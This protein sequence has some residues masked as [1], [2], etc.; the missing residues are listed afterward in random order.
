MPHKIRIL[1]VA[2]AVLL[3]TLSIA[4]AGPNAQ[5]LTQPQGRETAGRGAAGVTS[6][7]ITLGQSAP[8]TGTMSQLGKRMNVGANAYFDSVN[9]AGGLFG[10]RVR[11]IASDDRSDPVQARRNT[12]K[13]IDDGVFALFGY[14]GTTTTLAAKPA[15][16][17]AEVPLIGPMAGSLALRQ[18]LDRMIFNIRA[19]YADEIDQQVQEIAASGAH[20][21]AI[22]Y[23][24]DAFG[25]AGLAAARNSIRRRGFLPVVAVPVESGSTDVSKALSAV[26]ESRPGAVIIIAPDAAAPLIST[27]RAQGVR[28]LFYHVSFADAAAMLAA[29]GRQG[30][31]VL[32]TQVVPFPWE[33]SVPIVKEYQDAMLKKGDA[34]FDFASLEGYIAARVTVE[35]LRRAGSNLTRQGLV[36]A[37]ESMESIDLGGYVVN[38]GTRSHAGSTLVETT[39]I[40][41]KGAFIQ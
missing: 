18:P 27:L 6:T 4:I 2:T 33:P 41:N 21:I 15:L 30:P 38:F 17:A 24:N 14:V 32:V 35:G 5:R 26:S 12:E 1:A 34:A 10:R 28:P 23:Q 31:G 39:M 20:R 22:V 11:L 36:S 19:S 29:L 3:T 13:F 8:L 9:A 40:G 25:Q 16:D 7:E 37:L